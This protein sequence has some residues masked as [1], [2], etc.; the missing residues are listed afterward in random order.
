MLIVT[1]FLFSLPKLA[2]RGFFVC[3]IPAVLVQR[4]F[5]WRVCQLLGGVAVHIFNV[6]D[7]A[8]EPERLLRIQDLKRCPVVEQGR[9]LL[10]DLLLDFLLGLLLG[11]EQDGIGVVLGVDGEPGRDKGVGGVGF[12]VEC[13]RIFGIFWLYLWIVLKPVAEGRL[14]YTLTW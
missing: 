9:S 10:L 7:N 5:G 11:G 12:L 4:L 14:I 3:P 8:R 13:C 2:R 1:L 6:G